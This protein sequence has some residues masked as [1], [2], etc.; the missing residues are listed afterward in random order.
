MK[1]ELL[2]IAI[3]RDGFKIRRAAVECKIPCFTSLDTA[4]A[5]YMALSNS[6]KIDI[7]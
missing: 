3:E 7:I 4:N 1:K 5:L 6:K 2:E